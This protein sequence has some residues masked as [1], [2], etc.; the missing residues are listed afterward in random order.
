MQVVRSLLH[1]AYTSGFLGLSASALNACGR[2]QQGPSLA[3]ERPSQSARSESEALTARPLAAAR[4]S[5]EGNNL[6]AAV[7]IEVFSKQIEPLT[8]QRGGSVK[9]SVPLSDSIS[10]AGRVRSIEFQSSSEAL[11]T[12]A[13]A[14]RTLNLVV[15]EDASEGRYSGRVVIRLDNGSEASQPVSVT[16]IP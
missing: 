13:V 2:Q 9:V 10:E 15:A 8:L 5:D 1:I 7:R 6:Q 11:R 14:G 16:V 4:S 3:S 12:S